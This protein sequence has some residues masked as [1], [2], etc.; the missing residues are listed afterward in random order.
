MWRGLLS[1]IIVSSLLRRRLGFRTW[2]FVPWFT[3]VSWLIA[4]AHGLGSGSDGS[5]PW[6]LGLTIVCI[7]VVAA[8]I[9]TRVQYGSTSR[10]LEA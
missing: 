10:A 9:A 7:A 5:S 6:M 3:Y 8:A 4:V 1:A 2:R